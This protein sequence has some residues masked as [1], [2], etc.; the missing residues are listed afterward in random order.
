MK[1]AYSNADILADSL[2]VVSIIRMTSIVQCHWY[3]FYILTHVHPPSIYFS[4]VSSQIA[5]LLA[6]LYSPTI[7]SSFSSPLSFL[8]FISATPLFW[9]AMQLLWWEISHISA[10]K[11]Y[12]RK[13]PSEQALPKNGSNENLCSVCV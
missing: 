5:F 9:L 10:S 2:I 12:K 13:Q 1:Q 8:K 4:L 7:L 6:L 11:F 3:W